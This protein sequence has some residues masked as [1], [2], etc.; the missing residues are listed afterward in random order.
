[1]LKVPQSPCMLSKLV[2]FRYGFLLV[3][4]HVHDYLQCQTRYNMSVLPRMKLKNNITVMWI[5]WPSIAIT[6]RRFESVLSWLGRKY[7]L[8]ETP[9]G[10]CTNHRAPRRLSI[11]VPPSTEESSEMKACSMMWRCAM[12]YHQS[13]SF[14]DPNSRLHKPGL[15]SYACLIYEQV[16]LL[17]SYLTV[18]KTVSAGLN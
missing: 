7:N 14:A 12:K 15:R 4:Q 2:I 10:H 8:E 17:L 11:T 13:G 9:R 16:I 3:L 18:D 6:C 1:M 5:D